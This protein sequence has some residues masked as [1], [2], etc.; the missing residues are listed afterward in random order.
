MLG[1][2]STQIAHGRIF[3]LVEVTYPRVSVSKR[4]LTSMTQATAHETTLPNQMRT[5]SPRIGEVSQNT[6]PPSVQ[7]VRNH[8]RDGLCHVLAIAMLAPSCEQQG[9]ID[10]GAAD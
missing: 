8:L 4:W 6:T 9:S 3:S 5:A 1:E 7:V 10:L 2:R